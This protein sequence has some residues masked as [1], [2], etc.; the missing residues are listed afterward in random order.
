[1]TRGSEGD[2]GLLQAAIIGDIRYS[3]DYPEYKGFLG[4]YGYLKF[5]K[6]PQSG[7]EPT[8]RNLRHPDAYRDDPDFP[9]TLVAWGQD[10]YGIKTPR[11]DGDP[12]VIYKV[13]QSTGEPTR[14]ATFPVSDRL[15]GNFH[16]IHL[17]NG[18]AYWAPVIK[19]GSTTVIQLWSYR[20]GDPTSKLR[21]TDL[22]VPSGGRPISLFGFDVDDGHFVFTVKPDGDTTYQLLF[23]DEESK[24]ISM[25]DRGL[26]V[27]Y[28]EIIHFGEPG[29]ASTPTSATSTGSRTTSGA[30]PSANP[31]PTPLASASEYAPSEPTPTLAMTALA[32]PDASAFQLEVA[33]AADEFLA[34]NFCRAESATRSVCVRETRELDGSPETVYSEEAWDAIRFSLKL[35]KRLNHSKAAPEHLLYG[36]VGNSEGSAA[37]VLS[38]LGLDLSAVQSRLQDSLLDMPWTSSTSRELYPDVGTVLTPIAV[39]G[40]REQANG[41]Y[42][43]RIG[44]E[45]LLLAIL[46]EGGSGGQILGSM[47]VTDALVRASL[48]LRVTRPPV[49]GRS[50]VQSVHTVT[51]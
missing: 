23:Y 29:A 19:T 10:L 44:P 43:D 30:V 21:T 51:P 14:I 5:V 26:A 36:L 2:K 42:A 7:G 12:V 37:R 1:M 20:L 41:L 47:G 48:N 18:H 22:K 27:N 31:T 38:G 33:V 45:H 15:S 50:R 40:A 6:E 39:E 46:Q 24:S 49:T 35:A 28:A 11:S 8:E 32:K 13:D 25:A 34:V 9:F 3:Y 4:Y 17:D 16:Q